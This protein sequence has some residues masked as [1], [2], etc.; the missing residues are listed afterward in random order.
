[1]VMYDN[2]FWFLNLRNITHL[3]SVFIMRL[4]L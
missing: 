3:Y 1:M 2:V 4:H